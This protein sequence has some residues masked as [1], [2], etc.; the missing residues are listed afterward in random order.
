VD[1]TN[2]RPASGTKKQRN[3]CRGYV[4]GVTQVHTS[5]IKKNCY[6]SASFMTPAFANASPML[7]R[8]TYRS[9]SPSVSMSLLEWSD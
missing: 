2:Q 7:R 3:A 6:P 5:L 8:K 1:S 4:W 9:L